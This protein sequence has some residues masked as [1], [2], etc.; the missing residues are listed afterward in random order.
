MNRRHHTSTYETDVDVWIYTTVVM[1]GHV[2]AEVTDYAGELI[3]EN[4]KLTVRDKNGE[5]CA[6]DFEDLLPDA[7]DDINAAIR[8]NY[9][10][11]TE[12]A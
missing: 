8:E 1:D 2:S 5:N 3:I 4:H 6:V 11:Y 12:A 7:Q 10:S 9:R